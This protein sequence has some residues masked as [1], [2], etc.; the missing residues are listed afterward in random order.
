M[1]NF[2]LRRRLDF[3]G[4]FLYTDT[5]KQRKRVQRPK[6]RRKRA[7]PPMSQMPFE[8]VQAI[9][10]RRRSNASGLHRVSSK[11]NWKKEWDL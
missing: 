9:Q 7:L 2:Y 11:I 10:E 3:P 4:H 5:M 8:R 6:A 1:I